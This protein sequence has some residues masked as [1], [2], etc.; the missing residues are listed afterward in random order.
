M[1]NR[2]PKAD[3]R[4]SCARSVRRRDRGGPRSSRRPRAA[5][6]ADASSHSDRREHQPHAGDEVRPSEAI[7]LPRRHRRSPRGAMLW[8]MGEHSARVLDGGA[9]PRG[10]ARRDRAGTRARTTSS[11]RRSIAASAAAPSRPCSMDA[12]RRKNTSGC[13]RRFRPGDF[14]G[15]LKFGYSS[16]GRVVHGPEA[17]CRPPRVCALPAPDP[18]RRAGRRRAPR[19]RGGPGRR[20]RCWPPTWKPP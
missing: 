18:L 9:R 10:T 15:P 6:P 20:G 4:P 7:R 13:G 16:V 19:A 11:W 3:V 17:L 5:T 1:S 14:P 8:P 2:A 12:S